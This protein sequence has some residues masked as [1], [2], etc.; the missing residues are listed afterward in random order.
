MRL[1]RRNPG[2]S[3]LGP[4]VSRRPPRLGVRPRGVERRP[5]RSADRRRRTPVPG[6][7]HGRRTRAIRYGT[8]TRTCLG[9]GGGAPVERA[10]MCATAPPR[11]R[12][13]RRASRAASPC[14][15]AGSRTRAHMSSSSSRG[16]VAPRISVR[17]VLKISAARVS[18]AGPI[19]AACWTSRSSSSAGRSSRPLAA[20]SGTFARMTRSRKRSSRSAAKRRGSWPPSMTRSTAWKTAAP[21]RRGEGVDDLVE[22][23]AVGVAEQRDGPGVGDALVVGPGEQLVED[24]QRVTRGS[25]AGPD[26]ERQRGRLERDALRGEDLLQ[27]R[28]QRRGRDQPERV[29]VGP[30]LD[31]RR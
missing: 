21:S 23:V 15:A 1:R 22:Q 4:V 7:R 2:A 30:R 8:R 26:D 6:I 25:G 20:A 18:S 29:V 3:R 28:A 27:Q 16:E 24:G 31:G 19:D 13:S 11:S 10:A 5:T 17:P 12:R 9:G 14:A